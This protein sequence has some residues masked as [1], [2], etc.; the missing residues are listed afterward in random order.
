MGTLSQNL[1]YALRILLKNPGFTLVVVIT[2]ALGVGANTAI[3]SVVYSALL[4]PLPYRNPSELL[5]LGES[6]HQYDNAETAQVSYPDYLDWK[7]MA[8]SVRSFA[9]F[10]GD[11]FTLVTNGEPKSTFAAQVTPNFFSTLGVKPALGRDFLEGENQSDGPHV[12][13]VSYAFWRTEFAA[14]PNVLGR[15]I[16]LDSKPAMIVGVL[17]REF[18][19]APAGAAPIWVPL[20]QTGGAITR[21][22]LR[23][24]NVIGRISPGFTG[25]QVRAEMEGINAQLSAE[26]P[27]EN[28]STFFIIG[29]LRERIV[30]KVRL[31]LLVLLGQSGLCF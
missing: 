4:R 28:G 11:A 31:L 24:L 12:A 9:A 13:I 23:W 27:K 15:I 17:P 10:S 2:L 29:G 21:R 14:D 26:Y 18:E 7:R 6:R 19:F 30:G 1:R 16:H 20:H 25:V 5:T 3:F 8:K 22:S